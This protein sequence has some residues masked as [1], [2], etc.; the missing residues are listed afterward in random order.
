MMPQLSETHKTNR[1]ALFNSTM[2]KVEDGDTLKVNLL[3]ESHGLD[4]MKS[5][6][7]K[8]LAG[9]KFDPCASKE[10]ISYEIKVK[11]EQAKE[12]KKD[13]AKKTAKDIKAEAIK[14]KDSQI[15]GA[16]SHSPVKPDISPYSARASLIAGAR[17][18]RR[19]KKN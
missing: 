13:K 14:R 15:R 2:E 11:K 12:E 5:E 17:N 1:L 8:V 10:K 3:M 16:S 18:Q 7:D 4:A 19:A 6:L 9:S